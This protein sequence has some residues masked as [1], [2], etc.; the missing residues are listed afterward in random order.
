MKDSLFDE[1][2][3]P[4]KIESNVKKPVKGEEKRIDELH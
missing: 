2:P 3:I 4:R 1:K